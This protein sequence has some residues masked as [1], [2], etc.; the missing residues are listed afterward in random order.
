MP[1]M[2]LAGAALRRDIS[3][4]PQASE[5]QNSSHMHRC[6]AMHGSCVDL[7]DDSQHLDSVIWHAQPHLCMRIL[8][9]LMP[10]QQ[11]LKAFSKASPLRMMLTPQSFLAKST[12]VYV[13]PV[14]VMT[15][16]SV[17][18]RCPSPASTTCDGDA[19]TSIPKPRHSTA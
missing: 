2:R 1:M 15:L 11:A 13:R 6:A 4:K 7:A 3:S 8:P 14:G 10:L 12:P 19:P 9:I 17:N 5:L 16:R 18:G